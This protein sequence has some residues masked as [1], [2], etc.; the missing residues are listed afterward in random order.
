LSQGLVSGSVWINCYNAFDPV[1]PA[2]GVKMSGYGRECGRQH[3]E[4]YL[5][6]K[7]VWFNTAL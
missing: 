6:V 2:G 5:A 1:V 4:D 7:S 3:L